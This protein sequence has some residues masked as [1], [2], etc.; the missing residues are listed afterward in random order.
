MKN[1]TCYVIWILKQRACNCNNSLDFGCF[2]IH[3]EV[4][5][6]LVKLHFLSLNQITKMVILKVTIKVD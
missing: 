4:E 1:T 3:D 2:Q 6:D 5:R